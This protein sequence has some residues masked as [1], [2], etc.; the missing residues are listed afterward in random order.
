MSNHAHVLLCLARDPDARLRDIAAQ[1]GITERGVFSV[2][3]DLE[4]GGLIRRHREGRR[5]RYEIDTSAHLRHRL[6]AAHTVGEL[7]APLLNPAEARR[8]GIRVLGA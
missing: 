6:E 5:N 4:A 3:T 2:I 1:V 8:L 7:L